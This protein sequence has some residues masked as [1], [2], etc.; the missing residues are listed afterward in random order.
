MYL[1]VD[2]KQTDTIQISALISAAPLAT[3][4]SHVGDA[5]RAD[6]IPLIMTK[7]KLIEQIAHANDLH[8][9]LADGAAV[10]AIFR[11]ENAYITP[12]FY[13]SKADTH[14]VVPTWNY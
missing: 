9:K 3:L 1:P 5:L 14:E 4:V 10:L 6:H 8:W 2:F 13:P 11:G 7:T 12:N